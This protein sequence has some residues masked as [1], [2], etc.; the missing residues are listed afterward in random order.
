MKKILITGANGNYGKSTIDFL[1]KKG[2]NANQ[3]V[4]LVRNAEKGAE[5]KNLGIE[6]KI[7]DY[8][9]YNSMI[10]AFQGIE[11]VLLISGTDVANRTKQH[12]NV[13]KAAKESG[14]RHII[15]TSIE[16][17]N[18]S[19]TS[20]LAFVSITHLAT[21]KLLKESGLNYTILRNTLYVDFIP[22]FLGEK[23]LETGIY[24]PA[25]DGKAGF[26]LRSEMAE[27]TANILASGGHESKEYHFSSAEN[28]SFSEIASI[29]KEI[30]GKEVSYFSPD[31][32]TFSKT[33]LDA[34]VPGEAVAILGGFAAGIAAGELENSSNDLEILLGRKPTN[35]KDFLSSVYRQELEKRLI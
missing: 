14:V 17:K 25:A 7:G 35:V 3:L 21:E 19:E 27:A 8:E 23:V 12:E 33:L 1:L 2:L 26:A 28:V 6:V 32:A 16:R 13:I 31:V 29:L 10:E 22:M 9:N 11:K 34:G 5:L 15:Y 18:E 4:G 20:P 24:L 30:S